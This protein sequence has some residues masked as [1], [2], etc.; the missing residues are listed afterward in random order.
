MRKTSILT[1][2]SVKAVAEKHDELI[3]TA[4]LSRAARGRSVALDG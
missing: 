2:C 1:E 4:V 3:K